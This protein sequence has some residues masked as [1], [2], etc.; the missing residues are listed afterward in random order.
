MAGDT[1]SCVSVWFSSSVG[2]DGKWWGIVENH[3][4]PQENEIENGTFSIWSNALF[5]WSG[6]QVVVRA[7]FLAAE[8]RW[9]GGCGAEPPR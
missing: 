7:G 6:G 9:S 4:N 5:R 3:V 2:N 8:G 1:Y